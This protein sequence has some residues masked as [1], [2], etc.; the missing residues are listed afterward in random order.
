M[1]LASVRANSIMARGSQSSTKRPQIRLQSQ[2]A[3]PSIA[4]N[5]VPMPRRVGRLKAKPPAAVRFAQP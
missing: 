2:P 3:L 1:R 4:W 5:A